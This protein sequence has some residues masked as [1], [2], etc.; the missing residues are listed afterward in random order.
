MKRAISYSLLNLVLVSGRGT[1]FGLTNPTR[2]NVKISENFEELLPQ[3]VTLIIL[4]AF[5]RFMHIDKAQNV[6]I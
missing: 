2:G 6:K 3:N 4:A 1:H 5:P